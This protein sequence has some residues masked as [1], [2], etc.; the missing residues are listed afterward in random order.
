MSSEILKNRYDLLADEQKIFLNGV[1]NLNQNNLVLNFDLDGVLSMTQIP[2]F[3]YVDRDLG[4]NFSSRKMKGF[5]PVSKWLVEDGLMNPKDAKHYEDGL[6]DNPEIIKLAPPNF[7][8]RALSYAANQRG[9]PQFI[10]TSRPPG[11]FDITDEWLKYYF[12]WIW[13]EP[14]SINIRSN[15]DISGMEFKA[16]STYEVY[17]RYPEVVTLDDLMPH[18]QRIVELCPNI[19]VIGFPYDEDVLPEFTGSNKVFVSLPVF[20]ERLNY[21]DINYS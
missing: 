9:I 12:N 14:G 7:R 11:L 3:N 15:N 8:L 18:L 6:W 4:T 2:V 13:I 16:K 5:N 21:T 1:I 20:E 10:T 17:K 19:G